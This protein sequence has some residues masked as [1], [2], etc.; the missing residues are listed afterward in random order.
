MLKKSVRV[1]LALAAS[2]F[3]DAAQAASAVHIKLSPNSGHPGLTIAVTG[4]GFAP[5][6]IVDLSF[7]GTDEGAST[8]LGNGNLHA[9]LTVPANALPGLHKVKAV[10]RTDGVSAGRKFLVQTDWPQTGFTAEG[11]RNNIYE[12]V[13]SSANVASLAQAWTFNIGTNA[14]TTPA[15]ANGVLYVAN[16]DSGSVSGKTLY[17]LDASTGATLW[18]ATLGD[19]VETSPIV[20]NGMVY[21]AVGLDFQAFNAATGALVWTD[22]GMQ[23]FA[24]PVTANGIIYLSDYYGRVH[25]LD[26]VTGAVLWTTSVGDYVVASPSVAN[27]VVYVP[28]G[29]DGSGL[30]EDAFY[31]LDAATGTVLWT[32]ATQRANDAPGAVANGVFYAGS[33]DHLFY[34]LDAATGA[35]LWSIQIGKAATAPTVADGLV[36]ID[37]PSG[38]NRRTL[39]AFDAATGA[40]RWHTPEITG[41]FS[42]PAA[43]NGVVYSGASDGN[44]YAFDAASGTT[45]WSA[46]LGG[47]GGDVVVAN[48]MVFVTSG[49]GTVHAFALN[50]AKAL[51]R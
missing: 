23:P 36:Y 13:L 29:F 26:A 47:D 30:F 51:G 14:V 20:T 32:A 1:A 18:T 7:D 2:L 34:A 50:G 31:A 19:T 44:V 35:T 15:V 11:T 49:N 45:L 3:A 17:A 40:L 48:G 41:D 5:R 28:Q 16:L 12:N 24:S 43:A 22:S 25:A 8:T 46:A 39:D 6:E 4:R 9:Q 10:G 38:A 37:F 33:D 21:L 27:G 42:P